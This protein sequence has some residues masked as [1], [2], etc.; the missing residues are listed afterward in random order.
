MQALAT[1]TTVTL[2][3]TFSALLDAKGHRDVTGIPAS[4]FDAALAGCILSAI[5]II[6]LHLVS[7]FVLLRST[8][9]A[10]TKLA[11]SSLPFVSSSFLHVALFLLLTGIILTSNAHWEDQMAAGRV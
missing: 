1:A 4:Q 5:L 2:L 7:F 11:G 9:W 6:L 3:V 10:S 8:T